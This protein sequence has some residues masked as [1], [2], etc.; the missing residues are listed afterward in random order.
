MYQLNYCRV[1]R[2]YRETNKVV[3]VLAYYSDNGSPRIHLHASPSSKIQAT[4]CKTTF[5]S[6]RGKFR[7]VSQINSTLGLDPKP[8]VNS[9]MAPPSESFD[10]FNQEPVVRKKNNGAPIK[11]LLPLIYA[12]VLPLI[13]IALRHKPVVRDRLFFAVLAGAFAHGSYLVYNRSLA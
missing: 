4:A 10:P 11:F 12:P 1:T 6:N 5:F 13:R 8:A 9:A 3:D 2:N 7:L